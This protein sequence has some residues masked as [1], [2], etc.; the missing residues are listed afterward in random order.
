M[1]KHFSKLAEVN[2]YFEVGLHDNTNFEYRGKYLEKIILG[3]ND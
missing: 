3:I 1:L 2:Y